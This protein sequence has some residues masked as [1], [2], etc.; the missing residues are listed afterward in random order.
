MLLIVEI[1]VKSIEKRSGVAADFDQK[2]STELE[3]L[4]LKGD[5]PLVLLGA[6]GSSGGYWYT[7]N[8]HLSR[9]AE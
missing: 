4:L 7:N 2:R 8:K 5:E 3:F 6:Y 1:V 9:R